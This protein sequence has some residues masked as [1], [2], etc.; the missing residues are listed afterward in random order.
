MRY[1]IFDPN[2]L[3]EAVIFQV[4]EFCQLTKYQKQVLTTELPNVIRTYKLG[5]VDPDTLAI[6]HF[7]V[8][9]KMFEYV[10][11][12]KVFRVLFYS[13]R[14]TYLANESLYLKLCEN[15]ASIIY[16]H[17][18]KIYNLDNDSI[19]KIIVKELFPQNRN[20]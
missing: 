11:K 1:N 5:N 2:A 3:T 13:Q 17:Y 16:E 9:S 10:I 20:N 6:T 14:G 4:E 15:A 19:T 8:Y 18:R 12:D 7:N